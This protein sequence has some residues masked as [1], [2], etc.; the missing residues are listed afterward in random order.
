MSFYCVCADRCTERTLNPTAV[1]EVIDQKLIWSVSVFQLYWE[2][3]CTEFTAYIRYYRRKFF[4]YHFF[5]KIDFNIITI[6]SSEV[7]YR[8]YQFI[9]ELLC[10]MTQP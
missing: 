4:R 7:I 2:H 3:F 6:Q 1:T 10:E 8:E 5:Y 9:R